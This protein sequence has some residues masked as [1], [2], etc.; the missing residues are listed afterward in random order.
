VL[1]KAQPPP[2]PPRERGR[3]GRGEG[4][5]DYKVGIVPLEVKPV[6]QTLNITLTPDPS[7]GEPGKSVTYTLRATNA[8][9]QPVQ[10]ALSLDL[11]DKAVLTLLAAP[12][13]RPS[14]KSSMA[15]AG[16]GVQTSSGL[17]VSV[18]RS[19]ARDRKRPGRAAKSRR[20]NRGAAAMLRRCGQRPPPAGRAALALDAFNASQVPSGVQIRQEFADTAYW[21]ASVVT[22]RD[23]KATVT[24]KL[25]DN[26]TT[27]VMRGVGVTNDT[28]VGE[29]TVDLV[30]T[31]P[32]LI[33]PVT[34]RFFVVGDK[35]QLAAIVNN[36]TDVPLQA[37]IALSA[38]GVT[39]PRPPCRRHHRRTRRGQADLGS[40]RPRRD[41]VRGDLLGCGRKVQRRQPAATC[42][43]PEGSLLVY[44]TLRPTSWARRAIAIRWISHRGDRAAAQVR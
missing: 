33:R 13:G 17:A 12:E 2:N 28:R 10:A 27:W 8:T 16:W 15:S 24:V 40:D 6:A 5:A 39:L 22:D 32:L 34:P 43:R 29:Q 38:T 4:V 41:A 37:T 3:A 19:A 26:L 36:N 42:H 11:V 21:N 20:G 18:N 14:W 25:P 35:A 44:R 9:G 7:Q 30:S 23:G 1:V 31:K